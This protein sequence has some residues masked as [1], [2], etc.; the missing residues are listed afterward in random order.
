MHRRRSRSTNIVGVV[1]DGDV[2]RGTQIRH[3]I[4]HP[5]SVQCAEIAIDPAITDHGR[6]VDHEAFSVA[7]R[8]LWKEGGFRTRHVAFG[9]DGRDATFRRLA[10]PTTLADD[11]VDAARYELSTYLPYPLDE[12][13]TTVQEV[14]RDEESVD[15]VVVAVRRRTVEDLADAVAQAGLKLRD[16]TLSST[17]LGIGASGSSDSTIV[18]V[19]GASTTIVVRRNGRATVTRVLTG[20]GGDRSVQAADELE[21]ALAS[22]DQF[23]LGLGARVAENTDPRVRRFRTVAEEV[24]AAIRFEESQQHGDALGLGVELTGAYGADETLVSLMAAGVD[25]P[26]SVVDTPS[27]WPAQHSFAAFMT[28]AGVALGSFDRVPGIVHLDVPSI[29]ERDRKRRDLRVGIIAGVLALVPVVRLVETARADAD[30]ADERATAAEVQADVLAAQADTFDE[31]SELYAD[32]QVQRSVRV[33]ALSGEVWFQ[34]VLD[35]VAETIPD[36]TFLT[37][38]TLRRP[39]ATSLGEQEDAT[40]TFSG[41]ALD[42]GGAAQ[43]LLA[44]ESLDLI[45]DVWLVQSTASVYGENELPVVAFVGE[46]KLTP[47][48]ATPRSLGLDE[49]AS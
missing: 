15:V 20:G 44:V 35:E 42:Q 29:T 46:G 19:D 8:S 48:A 37:G 36:E 24:A 22:V 26:V 13:I 9:I 33:D 21:E 3:G 30:M 49:E 31:I 16:V 7:L 1:L 17:A 2:I 47:D 25:A 40:A 14:A 12:A 39:L 27:W 11:V 43:W 4:A 38:L 28:A 6:I 41:V 32:V 10:V 34:R 23:R 5:R 18:S 45:D